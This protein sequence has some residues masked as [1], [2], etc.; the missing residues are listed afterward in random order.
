MSE[1]RSITVLTDVSLIQ[2]VVQKG[3]ADDIV[4][5]AKLVG[6]QGATVFYARGMGVKE[7]LGIFSVAIDT[8][9]EVIEVIVSNEQADKVFEAMYLAGHLDT[10][11]KGIITLNRIEKAAT[12]IPREILEKL[13]K[14]GQ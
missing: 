3:Y 12:Y 7:R 10:P 11:G 14:E 4:Q 5:A 1:Q 6:A 8:E 9:K 13:Q 2:C